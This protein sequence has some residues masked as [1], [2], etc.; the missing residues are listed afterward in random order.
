MAAPVLIAV[1]FALGAVIGSFLNV[2]I[3]RVPRGESIVSPGSHCPRCDTPI[4][5]F[6]NVPIVSWIVL[7]GRCRA[8]RARI[9]LR[10][11]LV[12]AAA[13]AAAALAVQR[14][15]VTVAGVE[16]GV[17]AWIA[18]ALAFIDLDHQILPDAITLPSIAL[19]LLC[20]WWGGLTTPLEAVLGAV[21]GAAIPAAVILVY[22]LLRGE[23]GMGWGDV[24]YLAAI[25][26]VLGIQACLWV[27]VV[28]AVLGAVVGL[29]LIAAG[30]GGA[31][32]ALPFGTFLSGAVILWLYLPPAWRSFTPW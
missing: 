12:E 32:T 14:W 25:G 29:G 21:V 24:K 17:F 7:G 1:A 23:E 31:R 8:C 19:G 9:S 26:A 22:R 6:D 20:A 11:P 27:L 13:A 2:V 30:R 18:L 10:Y 4:R 3:H 15:G 5:W 16:A 28:G